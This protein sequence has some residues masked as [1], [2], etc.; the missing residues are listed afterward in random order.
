[1]SGRNILLGL[2]PVIVKKKVII[3]FFINLDVIIKFNGT[4][5][6]ELTKLAKNVTV[7]LP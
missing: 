7:L 2:W 1:M 4:I 3:N 5:I 6:L